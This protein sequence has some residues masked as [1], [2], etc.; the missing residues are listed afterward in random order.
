MV[1]NVVPVVPVV[2][3]VRVPSRT[4]KQPTLSRRLITQIPITSV[5]PAKPVV[6]GRFRTGGTPVAWVY[7]RQP[8]LAFTEVTVGHETSSRSLLRPCRMRPFVGHA[9]TRLATR[10]TPVVGT[11]SRTAPPRRVAPSHVASSLTAGS[12]T[13]TP[14][15]RV[16]RRASGATLLK[17]HTTPPTTLND[18]ALEVVLRLA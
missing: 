17:E 12:T 18:G 5:A 9:S 15:R 6:E 13:A 10:G 3:G 1:G 11:A 8:R 7:P 4:T 14:S 16:L 2:A